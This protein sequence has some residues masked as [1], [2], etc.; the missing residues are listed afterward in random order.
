MAIHVHLSRPKV[1]QMLTTLQDRAE[2]LQA[3]AAEV[4]VEK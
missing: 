1:I 2:L 3:C 4:V